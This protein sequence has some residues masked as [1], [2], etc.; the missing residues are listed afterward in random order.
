MDIIQPI[1]SLLRLVAMCGC[2][3]VV[4]DHATL[5]S[6]HV[7]TC[8]ISNECSALQNVLEYA[9]LQSVIDVMLHILDDKLCR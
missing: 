2:I 1:P 7:A 5:H 4:V 8:L 6:V 3:D 9:V